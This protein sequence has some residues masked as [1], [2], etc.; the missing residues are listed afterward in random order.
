MLGPEAPNLMRGEA[1]VFD[2]QQVLDPCLWP[3]VGACEPSRHWPLRE[4]RHEPVCE[5]RVLDGPASGEKG[6]KGGPWLPQ[7]VLSAR[8]P[9]SGGAAL[10]A[11]DV[12]GYLAHKKTHPP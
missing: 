2:P 9:R 7:R 8:V 12:Q 3:T 10:S 5:D 11:Q 6:S 4:T 1:V